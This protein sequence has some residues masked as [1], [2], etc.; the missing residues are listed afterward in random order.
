MNESTKNPKLIVKNG[1]YLASRFFLSMLLS[2]YIAR[3]MLS[4]LGDVDFGINNVIGGLIAMFAI[5]SMPI[6]NSLQRYFNVE[7]AKGNIEES[8]VFSTALRLVLY[9]VAAMLI[10]YETIGLYVVSNI[11]DYPLE[12]TIAVQ[13]TYQI[14]ALIT[15]F[16][17][18]NIPFSALL[19]S[20]EIMG[21]PATAELLGSVLKLVMLIL[22]P[23]VSGDM[24]ILFT[25]SLLLIS[26]IQ[27]CILYF[28]TRAKCSN[29]K[30][31]K[32]WDKSLQR[33]MLCFSGW[34]SIESLAGIC[35]T[36]LSNLLINVFGGV[37][38]NT[39]N[40]L[41]KSITSAISSFTINVVKAAEPQITSSTVL[42][43]DSYR[44]ELV[45]LSIKLAFCF[46]GYIAIFFQYDGLTFLRIWLGN[47]PNYAFDF[48]RVMV[49]SC[50]F[51]SIMLPLRSMIIATGQ[52]KGYFTIYGIISIMSLLLMYGLLKLQWPIISA[53]YIVALCSILN[54]INAVY[55]AC[56]VTSF[57]VSTFLNEM[58]RGI[59]VASTV[60]CVYSACKYYFDNALAD[61]CLRLVLSGI[62]MLV[63][64][65]LVGL[66]TKERT[67]MYSKV[68]LIINKTRNK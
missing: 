37:L 22:L 4:V 27:F 17:F 34:N 38:Y 14:T 3:L 54:S 2:F 63:S 21:V 33:S 55:T 11:L 61:V 39:A 57:R 51:S 67:L 66:N 36:Y 32:S 48:C 9:L 47:V 10:C 15:L 45:M 46:T 19:Y 50:I 12:R 18:I 6:T 49:F 1:I 68:Q 13:W 42:K 58:M 28:R 65:V 53:V 52:I 7:F 5:I 41:S 31:T 64:F 30:I 29:I 25:G 23:F 62:M 26:F 60:F 43:N 44:D 40:G 8:V 35:I 24:L 20:K 16:S 59:A 56:R